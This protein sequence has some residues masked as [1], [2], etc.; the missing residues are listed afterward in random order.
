[1]PKTITSPVERFPGSVTIADPMR[2]DQAQ[3]VEVALIAIQALE[4]P[5]QSDIDAVTIPAIMA[6][7]EKWELSG[8]DGFIPASPR[9]DSSKLINWLFTQILQIYSGSGEVQDPNE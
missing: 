5:R 9:V 7:V 6:N 2:I 1:M 8:V 3:A 4:T